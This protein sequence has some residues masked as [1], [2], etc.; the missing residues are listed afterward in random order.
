MVRQLP[1]VMQVLEYLAWR[2]LGVPEYQN[3]LHKLLEI[4]A[5]PPLLQKSSESLQSMGVLEQYFTM[6]SYLMVVL[7]IDTEVFKVLGV[8]YQLLI[9]NKPAPISA[10]SLHLCHRAAETSRLPIVIT[11]L[12]EIS[13]PTT[14]HSVLKVAYILAISSYD[15]CEFGCKNIFMKNKCK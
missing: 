1:A 4:C 5:L 15:C 6:L 7:P 14:Y 8:V 12:A 3:Y 13:S 10:V 9:R 11:E 2:A